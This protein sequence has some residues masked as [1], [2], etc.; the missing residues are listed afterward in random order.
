[1]SEART[2]S[3]APQFRAHF[4]AHVAFAN[5]G[6]LT[7]EGFRIDLP[8][9]ELDEAAGD[10]DAPDEDS[11]RDDSGRDPPTA[12][13]PEPELGGSVGV[14]ASSGLSS[15]AT[16]FRGAVA[17]AGGCEDV[18]ESSLDGAGSCE[19]ASTGGGVNSI[20]FWRCSACPSDC[21]A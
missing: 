13:D 9:P 10:S 1:M 5:G 6:G 12:P 8:H 21:P 11:G 19:R 17:A 7:A 15:V 2:V 16:S 14:G 18:D 4:D 20:A 3:P